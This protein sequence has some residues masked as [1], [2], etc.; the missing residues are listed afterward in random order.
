[1]NEESTQLFKKV[2]TILKDI[3]E[4]K[5]KVPLDKE[6]AKIKNK[7]NYLMFINVEC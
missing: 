2:D 7:N 5:R 4:T 1:M 6:S 3:T